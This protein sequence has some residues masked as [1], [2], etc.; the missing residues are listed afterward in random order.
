MINIIR[1]YWGTLCCA[2]EFVVGPTW[3]RRREKKTLMLYLLK[4]KS[5]KKNLAFF[6]VGL[7][8]GPNSPKHN[9]LFFFFFSHDV[10]ITQLSISFHFDYGPDEIH[11]YLHDLY[12]KV[13]WKIWIS[14]KI[15]RNPQISQNIVKNLSKLCE[16]FI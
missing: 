16:E 12:S 6:G 2:R 3:N 4:N 13:Q 9:S 11:V 10:F 7:D 15:N 14:A 1:S 8:T 5:N